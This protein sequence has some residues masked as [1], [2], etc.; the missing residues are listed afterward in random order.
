MRVCMSCAPRTCTRVCACACRARSLLCSLI[1]GR[2][3]WPPPQSR[4]RT[5]APWESSSPPATPL[6][7][8][9][10][11]HPSPPLPNSRQPLVR[12][13]FLEFCHFDEVIQTAV[14][15]QS[16]CHIRPLGSEGG[17]RGNMDLGL[18]RP[19]CSFRI[20]LVSVTWT[21]RVLVVSF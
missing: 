12:S 7:A 3:V 16:R 5:A 21:L 2:F 19:G 6:Q 15:P 17:L 1:V 14:S 18:Q 10:P 4:Y 11:P 8:E 9:T 20:L 13:L